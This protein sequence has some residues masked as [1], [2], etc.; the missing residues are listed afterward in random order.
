MKIDPVPTLIRGVLY[1][2]Q[3]AAARAL[4]VHYTTVAKAMEE[5]TLDRVGLNPKGR[6]IG[7]PVEID[8]VHYRSIRQASKATGIPKWKIAKGVDGPDV[9][10]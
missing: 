10:H 4:G 8:G 1:P 5:G 2:S 6:R 7:Q 9:N 3:G